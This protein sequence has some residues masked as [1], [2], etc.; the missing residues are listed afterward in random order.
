MNYS[1]PVIVIKFTLIVRSDFFFK[2]SCTICNLEFGGLAYHRPR[3][4]RK[5]TFSPCNFVTLEYG[6]LAQAKPVLY[7]KFQHV[8]V[9]IIDALP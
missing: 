8:T 4:T 2:Y 1:K 6:G 9:T 5:T 3:P 7:S